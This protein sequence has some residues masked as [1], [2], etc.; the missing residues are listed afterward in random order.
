LTRLLGIF[1]SFFYE[2]GFLGSL[3]HIPV[4]TNI[5]TTIAGILSAPVWFIWIAIAFTK[6]K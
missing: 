5:S 2:A 4:L 6:M 1:G 3:L